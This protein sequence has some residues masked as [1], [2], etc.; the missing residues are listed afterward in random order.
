EHTSTLGYVGILREVRFI[1]LKIARLILAGLA[2]D[3][4]TEVQANTHVSFDAFDFACFVAEIRS[5]WIEHC[6]QVFCNMFGRIGIDDIDR[7]LVRSVLNL[8]APASG[9]NR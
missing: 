5:P 7:S 1:P 8:I 6:M 2:K 3:G 4:A 9:E